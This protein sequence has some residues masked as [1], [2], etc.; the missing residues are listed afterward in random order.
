[1]RAARAIRGAESRN[2]HIAA[3]EGGMK[4][5][6]GYAQARADESLDAV[7]DGQQVIDVPAP[8]FPAAQVPADALGEPASRGAG[9]DV[10]AR[11]EPA[12]PKG[13]DANR[14]RLPES[15]QQLIDTRYDASH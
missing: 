5:A 2:R 13:T 4:L 8:L 12:P 7:G 14:R 11:G 3:P 6:L 1:M 10:P 9:V 15:D